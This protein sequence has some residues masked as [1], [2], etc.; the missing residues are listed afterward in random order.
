V[1]IHPYP[2]RYQASA[3]AASTGTVKVTSP[4][5]PE[6]VT[7]PPPQFDGP[8]GVWSPETLLCAAVADCF[9]LTFRGVSRAAQLPWLGLECQVEGTLERVESQAR[10]THYACKARLTVA[11]GTDVEKARAL[12]ERAE[13]S[14]LISNSLGGTR[15]LETEVLVEPRDQA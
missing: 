11:K 8:E 10:F 15:T 13:H 6:L 3:A 7:A 1:S 5:L 12:L 4:A 14:C 2:H 9:I